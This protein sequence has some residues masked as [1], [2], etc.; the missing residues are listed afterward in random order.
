MLRK[1]CYYAGTPSSMDS[2]KS[3]LFDYLI[4]TFLRDRRVDR[5]LLLTLSLFDLRRQASRQDTLTGCWY[6]PVD[7][8]IKDFGLQAGLLHWEASFWWYWIGILLSIYLFEEFSKARHLTV[9]IHGCTIKVLALLYDIVLNEVSSGL[10]LLFKCRLFSRL[11]QWNFYSN[12]RDVYWFI[13]PI[14]WACF[15]R[16]VFARRGLC[17]DWHADYYTSLPLLFVIL[18]ARNSQ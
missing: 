14:F 13:E 7:S 1:S 8:P 18:L 4:L 6:C 10:D 12:R 9:F 2:T 5:S 3:G 11:W 17:S 16:W 15:H